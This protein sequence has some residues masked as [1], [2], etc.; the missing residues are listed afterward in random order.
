MKPQDQSSAQTAST[1]QSDEDFL[2]WVEDI[3]IPD[4]HES[5]QQ[6][7]IDDFQRLV[8]MIRDRDKVIDGALGTG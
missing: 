6:G 1:I 3:L 5:R 8:A 4:L 2:S 7:L